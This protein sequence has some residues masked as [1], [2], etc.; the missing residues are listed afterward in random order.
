MKQEEILEI[1]REGWKRLYP[2]GS[3][4]AALRQARLE[5]R[6]KSV[7]RDRF[8]ELYM[9]G[10][11]ATLGGYG[12]DRT[13]I[14]DQHVAACIRGSSDLSVRA[15]MDGINQLGI[16]VLLQGMHVDAGDITGHFG[17]MPRAWIKGE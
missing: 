12:G 10:P 13:Q 17:L 15:K 7:C 4:D 1:G 3:F 14:E 5:E 2:D 16:G 8:V 11:M 9:S 6:L